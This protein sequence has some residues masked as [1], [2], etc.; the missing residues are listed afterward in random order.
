MRIPGFNSGKF[1]DSFLKKKKPSGLFERAPDKKS[2][3]DILYKF[4]PEVSE[5]SAEEFLVESSE[6]FR[7]DPLE[8]F[9]AAFEEIL[10]EV[11]GGFIQGM[12]EEFPRRSFGVIFEEILLE[13]SSE[14][15]Y[16]VTLGRFFRRIYE[17]IHGGSSEKI[18]GSS[19][20]DIFV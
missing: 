15:V 14:E 10:G 1:I 18:L 3:D 13:K 6:K 19:L 11:S 8:E 16:R 4:L 2:L 12:Y 20:G 17:V 9:G 5:E 7:M